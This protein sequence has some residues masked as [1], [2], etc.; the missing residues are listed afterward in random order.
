MDVPILLHKNGT[1]PVVV[2]DVPKE[3]YYEA[4]LGID[5][6]FLEFASKLVKPMMNLFLAPLCISLTI[7]TFAL[8]DTVC[9]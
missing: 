1:V 4:L 5:S 8:P 9:S 3:Q 7:S 2:Y 6:R